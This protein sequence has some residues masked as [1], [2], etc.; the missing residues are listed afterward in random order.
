MPCA[1]IAKRILGQ[2]D[3]NVL[4]GCLHA[5]PRSHSARRWAGQ[6]PLLPRAMTRQLI[7]FS[8]LIARVLRTWLHFAARLREQWQM[9]SK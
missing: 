5:M 9:Y 7:H 3:Q 1:E 2:A 8:G 4:S 6:T